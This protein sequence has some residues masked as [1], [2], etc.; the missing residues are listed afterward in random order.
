[1]YS[2]DEFRA[3]SEL[4]YL[5]A[6]SEASVRSDFIIQ[7]ATV[8]SDLRSVYEETRVGARDFVSDE[9]AVDQYLRY[10]VVYL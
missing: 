3:T 4:E 1:M 8:E 7:D 9:E 2:D 5:A 6:N 10:L